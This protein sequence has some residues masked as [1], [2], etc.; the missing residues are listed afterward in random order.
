MAHLIL[1]GESHLVHE[2]QIAHLE[3]THDGRP[4][5]ER[6]EVRVGC[7]VDIQEHV[8]DRAQKIRLH[9]PKSTM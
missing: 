5:E 3:A 2:L 6:G 1:Y 9:S 8:D 4:Y 7:G